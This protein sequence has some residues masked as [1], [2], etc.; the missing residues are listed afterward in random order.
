MD[1]GVTGRFEVTVFPNSKS[2]TGAGKLVHSKAATK[3]YVHA[4]YNAFFASLEE[5][6]K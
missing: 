6:L 3:A 1:A 2:E 4:D 5:A